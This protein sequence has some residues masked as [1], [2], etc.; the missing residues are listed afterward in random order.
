MSAATIML[1]KVLKSVLRCQPNIF[2]ALVASPHSL[3]S[4]AGLLN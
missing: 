2:S 4:S 1:T 3:C